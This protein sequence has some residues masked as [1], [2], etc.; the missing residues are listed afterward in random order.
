MC[1]DMNCL[2]CKNEL[3]LCK[4]CAK[5]AK[6]EHLNANYL[7]SQD[8]CAEHIQSV[9]S[10]SQD[11]VLNTLCV[12][13][14]LKSKKISTLDLNTNTI[15]SQSGTI[16]TLCV[17]NLTV[18]SLN[19]CEK[20]RAAATLSG[21][22]TYGLGNNVE[23]NI[24]LDDPNNNV[25]LSPFSY[26][27][28]QSGY[29]ILSYTIDC[30]T[31]SGAS[32]VTGV[33]IGILDVTSNGLPLRSFQSAYLSFSAVQKATLSA[34]VL[35]NVGDIIRMTYNVLVFDQVSGLINFVGSVSLKGNGLFAGQSGFEIHY[36]SSLNCASGVACQL[37]SPITIPCQVVSVECN[38]H[39]CIPGSR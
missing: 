39:N 11:E 3:N 17:N 36:L 12:A 1:G 27:V 38:D 24:V 7:T 31:L 37:P 29:Y 20:Y 25:S 4:L 18:G 32:V 23:W 26:T 8:I 33:P 9:S 15:I 19:R 22:S 10:S 28:P 35:L 14:D 2:D 21:N 13:V 5:K 6:I 16:G 30:D 34:L